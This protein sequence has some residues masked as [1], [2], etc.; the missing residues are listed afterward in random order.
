MSPGGEE[1][2]GFISIILLFSFNQ[3]AY[4][5]YAFVGTSELFGV[6]KKLGC[7]GLEDDKIC[8]IGIKGKE[9]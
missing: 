3:I 6:D 5:T 1:L 8:F 7:L 2:L 9:G 4:D